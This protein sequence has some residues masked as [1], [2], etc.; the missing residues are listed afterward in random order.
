MFALFLLLKKAV[1]N[2]TSALD[3]PAVQG[4]WTPGNAA[5]KTPGEGRGRVSWAQFCSFCMVLTD[6]G[7]LDLPFSSYFAM[8]HRAELEGEL[9]PL[10]P[11]EFGLCDVSCPIGSYKVTPEGTRYWLNFVA[12]FAFSKW[13]LTGLSLFPNRAAT[14]SGFSVGW[15]CSCCGV[16]WSCIFQL[17]FYGLAQGGDKLMWTKCVVSTVVPAAPLRESR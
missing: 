14:W 2:C 6:F 3:S 10:P 17:T 4:L 7:S 5:G 13:E 9:P 1:P 12:F 15:P 8:C 11:A 16:C